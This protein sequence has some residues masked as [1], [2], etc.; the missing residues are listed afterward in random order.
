VARE[1]DTIH[2]NA[3]EYEDFV[4]NYANVNGIQIYYEFKNVLPE[5]KENNN[6]S[7]ILLVHGWTANRFRLHPLYLHYIEKGTS[8]F[9]LDLRGCGWS[10]KEAINDF[11]INK[12]S[13]DVEMFVKQVICEKFGFSS[14]ILIGHSMGGNICMKVASAIPSSIIRLILLSSSAYWTGNFFGRFKL[15]LY[16]IYYRF[17]YWKRYNGKKK[18]HAVHGLE[19]FPM[20]SNKYRSNGRTLFT[21]RECTIQG[22]KSIGSFDIRKEITTLTIPTLIVVGCEDTDAPPKL[23]KEIH[24]LIKNSTLVIIPGVNH[25]VVIGK[26]ITL[27]KEIDNFLENS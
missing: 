1:S 24:E 11:S 21:A 17:N 15:A 25:D 19:H 20:W 3:S 9:R 4:E 12:M 18:G 2:P 7:A 13:E 22:I 6:K 26:P 14:V 8:V 27:A 5:I 16:A 10:Q 23:S